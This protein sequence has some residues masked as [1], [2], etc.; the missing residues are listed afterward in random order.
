MFQ[1][2]NNLAFFSGDCLVL[3]ISC[4]RTSRIALSCT[5]TARPIG[6]SPQ[7]R[8]SR[9]WKANNEEQRCTRWDRATL[10][11]PLMS[12]I[13]GAIRGSTPLSWP[14]SWRTAC[15]PVGMAI[16]HRHHMRR[17]LSR[18]YKHICSWWSIEMYQD[19]TVINYTS[20]PLIISLSG[21]V[22]GYVRRHNCIKVGLLT[23]HLLVVQLHKSFIC[24]DERPVS[25]L[26]A[27]LPLTLQSSSCHRLSF[28]FLD[29]A[30][31]IWTC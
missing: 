22:V 10:Y 9:L 25:F 2:I 4:P 30:Q 1:L 29:Y 18:Q 16:L 17:L 6:L 24:L 23:D 8:L 7:S 21:L 11:R 3:W 14:A 20:D 28:C 19:Y 27:V 13:T 12:T 15:W 5:C 31:K 26:S